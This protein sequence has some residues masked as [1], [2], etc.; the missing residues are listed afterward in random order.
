[1]ESTAVNLPS[2]K[3]N[4]FEVAS[5]GVAVWNASSVLRE[6]L[7]DLEIGMAK[8]SDYQADDSLSARSTRLGLGQLYLDF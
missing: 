5:E 4:V 1:M 7:L 6:R 8:S 2:P 3:S